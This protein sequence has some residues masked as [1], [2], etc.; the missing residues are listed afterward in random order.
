MVLC[1]NVTIYILSLLISVNKARFFYAPCNSV[2]NQKCAL[3]TDKSEGQTNF[4]RL[5]HAVH[6]CSFSVLLVLFIKLVLFENRKMS[7]TI[8]AMRLRQD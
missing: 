3:K 6:E 8:T 4:M 7:I 1:L 5:F 2:A